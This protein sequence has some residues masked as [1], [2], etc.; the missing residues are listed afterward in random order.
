MA[1]PRTLSFVPLR[2]LGRSVTAMSSCHPPRAK[3]E[4]TS[5]ILLG[6]KWRHDGLGSAQLWRPRTSL[7]SQM[8][9]LSTVVSSR[10]LSPPILV[11][12]LILLNFSFLHLLV[13]LLFLFIYTFV[14]N[15][16]DKMDNFFVGCF[17]FL[18]QR[19]HG[20]AA[21]RMVLKIWRAFYARTR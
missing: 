17:N 7:L 20:F 12:N 4:A 16:K 11:T 15:I 19:S 5:S 8:S 10:R 18:H 13:E 6:R 1:C 14:T 9:Y 3:Q 2:F 21:R